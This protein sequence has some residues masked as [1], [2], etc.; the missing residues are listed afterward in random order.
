MSR[1]CAPPQLRITPNFFLVGAA[2]AGTTSLYN[3]LAQHPQIFMSPLKE[4]HFL[5]DEVRKENFD[6][7]K[8]VKIEQWELAFPRHYLQGN[9]SERF[10]SGP[11]F[12]T[13]TTT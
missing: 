2:K 13:G 12:Q 5:A 1:E 4:P 9:M 3:Y 8:R 11:G 6:E 7:D 10:S